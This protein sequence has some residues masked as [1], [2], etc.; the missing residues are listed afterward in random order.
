VTFP[1]YE[2]SGN[3]PVGGDH[4]VYFT[5]EGGSITRSCCELLPGQTSE[6]EDSITT[7]DLF[8]NLA[9]QTEPRAFVF[10]HVGG[11]YADL[12]VHD[13]DLEL[14]VEVHSA[15]GTFEWFIQ[16]ALKRG[17]RV[18]FVA[19]S[20]GHK[21]DP[22]ASYPGNS[23]FG[24]VGGL[25]C[26][27]AEKLDRESV[28][29]ALKARHFYATTGCRCLM[30][31][32]L[33]DTAGRAY[34]MGDVVEP[35][36]DALTLKVRLAGS[37]PIERVDVFNGIDLIKTLRPFNPSD[38]GRRIKVTWNGARV[39]G[40]DRNV[41]WDGSLTVNGNTIESAMPFNFW[42][43]ERPLEKR[44]G[45]QL[46][47][48]SFTTGTA[49]GL[50]MTLGNPSEGKIDFDT[51]QVKAAIDINEISIGPKVWECGGLE[52][53]LQVYRLPDRQE[54]N[55]FAFSLPLTGLKKGDNP[56][57]IRMEQEDGH[58]AWSSPVYVV[59]K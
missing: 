18:G 5:S 23:K 42:N 2:W 13:P 32:K 40:R 54:S 57:F 10:A 52:M 22:G 25:T 1:G 38:L 44:S 37:T 16:D 28:Y 8:K 58:Q 27:L 34:M 49:R 21:A 56:I 46:A 59:G 4:N 51:A 50:I 53:A 36:S 45:N 35:G 14:A 24:A 29:S 19:N 55:E 26:V 43:P 6:Y 20:D 3:T 47:W 11:R 48:K 7:K 9:K 12:S 33:E 39:R 30:E 15:W 31:V 17:Y 41:K